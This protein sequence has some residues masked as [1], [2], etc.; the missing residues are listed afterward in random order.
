MLMLGIT[1][2]VFLNSCDEEENPTTSV[3]NVIDTLDL[4]VDLSIDNDT[5]YIGDVIEF[6]FGQ[7]TLADSF[8]FVWLLDGGDPDSTSEIAP[9]VKY[10]ASGIYDA[11]VRLTRKED[12]RSF[13]GSLSEDAPIVVYDTAQGSFLPNEAFTINDGEEA[14][15]S[16]GD[17]T[18]ENLK[19][20]LPGTELGEIDGLA[21]EVTV[22]YNQPGIHDVTLVS[23]LN[24]YDVTNTIEDLVT[25]NPLA[26]I[27]GTV[28]GSTGSSE[29]D[30]PSA[31]ITQGQTIDF[32]GLVSNAV[33]SW[34]FDEADDSKDKSSTETN[35]SIR[36][37]EPGT[38]AISVSSSVPDD[39]L[40]ANASATLTVVPVVSEIA[41]P[42]GVDLSD[43]PRGASPALTLSSSST[44]DATYQWILTD[45]GDMSETTIG[46]AATLTYSFETEGNYSLVLITS[47][48]DITVTSAA[49]DITVVAPKDATL[50]IAESN[51]VGDQILLIFDQAIE[52]PSSESTNITVS[53]DGGAAESIES[54]AYG[55]NTSTLVVN[56]TERFAEGTTVTVSY[57]PSIM[58]GAGTNMP[59]LTNES[60]TNKSIDNL[61]ERAGFDYTFDNNGV[62]WS[63]YESKT[64]GMTAANVTYGD[65]PESV[66]AM[67]IR[68][69][70]DGS[71]SLN[72]GVLRT[73]DLGAIPAGDYT[74][75]MKF[76]NVNPIS[77]QNNAGSLEFRWYFTEF[78]NNYGNNDNIIGAFKKGG[79]SAGGAVPNITSGTFTKNFDG[80][81]TP[82]SDGWT[83]ISGMSKW[84]V[85]KL[86]FTVNTEM[87]TGSF[88]VQAKI[89][90]EHAAAESTDMIFEIDY[91]IIDEK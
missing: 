79:I 29:A 74:L 35:P 47:I 18:S 48:H 3:I 13:Y 83:E 51:I 17:I 44:V 23:S 80:E 36:F 63:I 10:A 86:D 1:L 34:T 54:V 53:V 59:T 42:A 88:V 33:V 2:S 11:S 41:I 65:T 32:T 12:G 50:S 67:S 24:G 82:Y 61:I 91:I 68:L 76:R 21:T 16:T 19:W 55:D 64:N 4:V 58:T 69:P 9:S 78:D 89:G 14:T 57:N 43:L 73:A 27:E 71:A 85:V 37:E 22:K 40:S 38:F 72:P 8:D 52:D 87:S 70:N 7:D 81:A 75:E 45:K 30:F 5:I 26:S 60:I 6:D 25:V 84:V 28:S 56:L 39:G 62:G 15:F 49:E 46:T 66:S 20:I 77:D 90:K 31:T